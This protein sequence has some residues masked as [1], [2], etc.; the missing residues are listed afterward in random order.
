MLSRKLS[1]VAAICCGAL[2]V[3]NHRRLVPA[4]HSVCEGFIALDSDPQ[5][6][7]TPPGVCPSLSPV[8]ARCIWGSPPVNTK[9]I[10]MHI[11]NEQLPRL[12]LNVYLTI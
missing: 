9:L 7:Q 10:L 1:S 11:S 5:K 3:I 2:F 12:S 6:G 8:F 4:F